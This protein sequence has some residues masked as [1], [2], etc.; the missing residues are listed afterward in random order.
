MK[1]LAYLIILSVIAAGMLLAGSCGNSNSTSQPTTSTSTS[2]TGPQGDNVQI[3]IQN[4]A[5][6]PASINVPAGT[7]IHWTNMDAAT[8]T[9]T[10]DT[11][12]FDSKN[13]SKGSNFS[14]TFSE[15]GTFT[16]HCGIHTFMKGTIIV[17]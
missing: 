16:Y 2:P 7:T 14:H 17:E 6:S 15:K 3:W 5:F 11:G 8:H 1:K 4:D 13:M 9:V 12:L 10:S